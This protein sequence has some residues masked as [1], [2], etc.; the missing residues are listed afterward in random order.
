MKFLKLNISIYAIIAMLCMHTLWFIIAGDISFII[1]TIFIVGY[2]SLNTYLITKL[3]NIVKTPKH[4]NELIIRLLSNKTILLTSDIRK[5][6]SEVLV[7][8]SKID[9]FIKSNIRICN[10]ILAG[11]AVIFIFDMFDI[12]ITTSVLSNF[13][14]I[15]LHYVI[16]AMIVYEVHIFLYDFVDLI[17]LANTYL[18][19]TCKQV[20]SICESL[21]DINIAESINTLNKIEETK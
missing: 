14:Y 9:N 8:N 13:I 18:F 17:S 10:Y 12:I 20:D 19:N 11:C 3:I 4:Y 21:P 5:H 1:L 16:C 6:I 7:S 2:F 15:Y